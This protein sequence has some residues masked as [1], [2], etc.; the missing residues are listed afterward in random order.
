MRVSVCTWPCLLWAWGRE[1]AGRRPRRSLQEE[2]AGARVMDRR[3]GCAW[4]VGG[5]CVA[6]G[7]RLWVPGPCRQQPP[8]P[9]PPS[10][11]SAPSALS[12]RRDIWAGAPLALLSTWR[13]DTC[14]LP[15]PS[16]ALPQGGSPRP[17]PSSQV[18]GSHQ[19]PRTR[20]RSPPTVSQPSLGTGR[21]PGN[22]VE[23]RMMSLLSDHLPPGPG[24][25]AHQV[26]GS[27][28]QS[29]EVP[30]CSLPSAPCPLL[31]ALC[32]GPPRPALWLGRGLRSAQSR[33]AGRPSPSPL[34]T[35]PPFTPA[36]AHGQVEGAILTRASRWEGRAPR[37]IPLVVWEEEPRF[38]PQRG[39]I[40]PPLRGAS[41]LGVAAQPGS[42]VALSRGGRAG[43]A[44]APPDAES[45][46]RCPCPARP[47]RLARC[48]A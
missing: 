3:L 12:C 6:P 7:K 39:S 22:V 18:L 41:E 36:C 28:Q 11:A 29:K 43:R 23:F 13:P 10:L 31:P 25:A 16:L 46:S 5:T 9:G 21:P 1:P 37:G 38:P 20:P 30:P 32:S 47:L 48:G 8:G 42:P 34:P 24:G 40:V 19:R 17:A 44:G 33:A 45:A 14:P 35:P 2:W 15:A 4:R 26:M 27:A